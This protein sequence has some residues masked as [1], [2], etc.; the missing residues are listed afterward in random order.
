M[1][2]NGLIPD[3]D[4]LKVSHHGSKYCST[5]DFLASAQAEVAIYSASGTQYGHP[6]Q[7]ALTRL[8]DS[9]ATIYGTNVHGSV[10]VTTDGTIYNV[11]LTN[12][13]A[14]VTPSS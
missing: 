13:V 7:E 11:Q 2:T 4:I 9:G 12:E 1:V 5:A 8:H 10:I 6:T 14:P 3:I